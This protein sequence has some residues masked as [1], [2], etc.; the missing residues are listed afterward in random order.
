[1]DCIW[2]RNNRLQANKLATTQTLVIL[3]CYRIWNQDMK[4][5][6]QTNGH[7]AFSFNQTYTLPVI[8]IKF[9][10]TQEFFHYFIKVILLQN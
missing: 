3:R 8:M 1:M 2:I 4:S 7:A 6:M 10:K 5:F 9:K